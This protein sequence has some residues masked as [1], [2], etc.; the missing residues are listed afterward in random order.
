MH[1]PHDSSPSFTLFQKLILI[2]LTSILF[3]V[4]IAVFTMLEHQND[5]TW[6]KDVGLKEHKQTQQQQFVAKRRSSS[7]ATPLNGRSSAEDKLFIRNEIIAKMKNGTDF[8]ADYDVF[9]EIPPFQKYFSFGA[10]PTPYDEKG[11]KKRFL[12]ADI[13]SENAQWQGIWLSKKPL[14]AWIPEFLTDDECDELVE[15]ATRNL[16]HSSVVAKDEHKQQQQQ[17]QPFVPKGAK[18]ILSKTIRTSDQAWLF[19][20]LKNKGSDINRVYG[21]IMLSLLNQFPPHS[22]EVMQVLRYKVGERYLFH[23]DYFDPNVFGPQ[24]SNRAVTVFLYL[25]DVEEGGETLF[26]FANGKHFSVRDQMKTF[27][28]MYDEAVSK[29][30]SCDGAPGLKVK[31]KKRSIALFYDMDC[32]GNLDPTSMHAGCEVKKGVKY[33]GTLW[34]RLGGL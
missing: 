23:E 3:L 26:P 9:K 15:V 8:E 10:C 13:T 6:W 22:N 17:Q 19:R 34:L 25:N 30:N 4:F 29:Q 2:V 14:V 31:P 7:S 32:Y 21:R 5:Q 18:Q 1:H 27:K 20:D 24:T 16:E 11:N 33:G 28:D 12:V